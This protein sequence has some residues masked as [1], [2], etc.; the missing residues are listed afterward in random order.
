MVL[1]TG[2]KLRVV[3]QRKGDMF[4]NCITLWLHVILSIFFC[5]SHCHVLLTDG[6]LK[7][8][9]VETEKGIAV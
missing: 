9:A 7:G 1:N 8:V 5:D 2:D 4:V 6:L 3:G